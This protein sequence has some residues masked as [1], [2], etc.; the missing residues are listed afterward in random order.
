M[1][2]ILMSGMCEGC[3]YADLELDSIDTMYGTK[4]WSLRCVHR[5]ACD[6]MEA[7]TIRRLLRKD[8][9]DHD[10]AD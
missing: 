10:A 3:E 9:G 7:V 4:R 5:N 6:N 2:T 8:G 1:I